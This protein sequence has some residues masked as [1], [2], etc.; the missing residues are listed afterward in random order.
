MGRGEA[1]ILGDPGPGA[2]EPARRPSR[3]LSPIC[4]AAPSKGRAE[5]RDHPVALRR[6]KAKIGIGPERKQ[7]LAGEVGEREEEKTL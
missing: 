3:G 1:Q 5:D 6:G 2:T 7:G 4:A